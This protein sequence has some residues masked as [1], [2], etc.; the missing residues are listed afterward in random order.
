MIGARED[1]RPLYRMMLGL[2]VA[3]IVI[4]ALGLAT[5]LR[6]APPGQRTGYRAHI[7]GVFAYDPGSGQIGGQP[8][9]RFHRDQAFAAQVD[10]GSL[11]PAIVVAADWYDSLDS[12]VGSVGPASAADLAGH[13]AVVPV[14]TP[15]ASR[16]NLPGSYTL[17]V[18]RYAGGQ[19]VELLGSESVVVLRDP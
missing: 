5:L 3:A 19:P 18:V 10:W 4:L 11:P 17:V 16:A 1:L 13:S 2:G 7:V 9:T 8:M 15:P 12:Q 6:F 14:R